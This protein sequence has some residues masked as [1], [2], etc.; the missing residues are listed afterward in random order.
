MYAIN[1]PFPEWAMVLAVKGQRGGHMAIRVGHSR[2]RD[3]NYE[4]DAIVFQRACSPD[5]DAGS[6]IWLGY[7]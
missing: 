1:R 4:F 3:G 7:G 2:W 5:L 6:S